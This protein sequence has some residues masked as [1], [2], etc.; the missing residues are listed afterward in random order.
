MHSPTVLGQRL[1]RV[2][3]VAVVG[4]GPHGDA[5]QHRRVQLLRELVPL[6]LGVILE[7][8]LVQLLARARQRGL[9]AVLGVLVDAAARV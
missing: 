2:G 3:E 7:D 8:G 5:R 9:L 6:L 4:V 1:V